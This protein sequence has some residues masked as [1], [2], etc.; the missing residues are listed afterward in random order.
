MPQENNVGM[1]AV[2]ALVSKHLPWLDSATLSIPEDGYTTSFVVKEKGS[3]CEQSW[4]YGR[5]GLIFY[6]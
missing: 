3:T 5:R 1:Q 2:E 6:L 4:H